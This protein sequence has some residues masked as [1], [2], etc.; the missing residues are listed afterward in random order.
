METYLHSL[1]D[2]VERNF[3]R[4]QVHDILK[5]LKPQ[6]DTWGI[7]KI[8]VKGVKPCLNDADRTLNKAVTLRTKTIDATNPKSLLQPFEQVIKEEFNSFYLFKTLP[9]RKVLRK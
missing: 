4:D 7:V 2:P 5:A 9:R 1:P 6:L 8:P 3:K